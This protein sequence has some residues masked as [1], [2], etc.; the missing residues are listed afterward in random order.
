MVIY[1]LPDD[2]YKSYVQEIEDVTVE[3]VYETASHLINTD[4]MAIVVVGDVEVIKRGLESL[5][6]GPVLVLEEESSE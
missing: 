1:G 5:K 6:E 3:D 2:Y 4:K